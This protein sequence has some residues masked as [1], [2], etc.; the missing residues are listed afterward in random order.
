MKISLSRV[1]FWKKNEVKSEKWCLPKALFNLK[2][3]NNSGETLSLTFS[4]N[5]IHDDL[6]IFFLFED[7]SSEFFLKIIG[8]FKAQN[9]IMS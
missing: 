9:K 6:E 3:L 7:E 5:E 8:N 4:L 1:Q 2:K